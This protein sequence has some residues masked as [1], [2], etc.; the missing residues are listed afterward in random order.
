MSEQRTTRYH[1]LVPREFLTPKALLVRAA[2]MVVAF[3][4]AHVLGLREY[5][6]ILC[7]TSPSGEVADRVS[8]LKGAIYGVLYFL[9]V[10]AAPISVIAAGILFACQRWLVRGSMLQRGRE[11]PPS[12]R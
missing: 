11:L 10:L 8:T 12:R 3:L 1:W 9:A 5:T 6:S 4:L 7:G 2:I